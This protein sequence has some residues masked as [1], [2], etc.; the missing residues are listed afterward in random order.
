MSNLESVA[1]SVIGPMARGEQIELD[2]AN[3]L[4]VALWSMKT[5]MVLD[6]QRG[7]NRW[8][9]SRAERD[10]LYKALAKS[11]LTPPLP[12]G[13]FIWIA[14]YGGEPRNNA[15]RRGLRFPGA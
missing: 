11:A 5:A 7:R 12:L 9:Y 1:K 10:L 8:L 13:S 14:R 15:H 2:A 6:T 4:L 3:Q